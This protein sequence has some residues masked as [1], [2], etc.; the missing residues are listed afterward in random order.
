MPKMRQY[1]FTLAELLIALLI[2][3]EIAAFTIPKILSAQQNGRYIAAAKEAISTLASAY[4]LYKTQTGVNAYTAP[5]NFITV[6]NYIKIQTSGAIDVR[7]GATGSS[8]CTSGT[9]CYVLANG[10]IIRDP[11]RKWGGD[12]TGNYFGGTST[13][14]Y[15]YFTIDPDG[16]DADTGT[17]NGPGKSVIVVLYY[18]GRITDGAN[19]KSGDTTYIEGTVYNSW[20]P[21]TSP[22][23]F[24]W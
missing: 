3:G 13:T 14:N 10:S 8:T 15:I 2:L 9:P 19:C 12:G 11:G 7:Y 23:W 17:T 16:I 22:P 6:L 21:F 24:S 1:G 18:N 5:S 4:D 20:C